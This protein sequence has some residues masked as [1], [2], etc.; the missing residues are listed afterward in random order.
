[1]K[2]HLYSFCSLTSL[3]VFIASCA[4]ADAQTNRTLSIYWNDVEGGGATLIVT[5]AGESILIDS[6]NPGARDPGRIYKT[7]SE[8][9]GLKK[10]DHYITTHFH[11]DHF[12][13][14]AELSKLIP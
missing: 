6:G 3:C 4:V 5:A 14:A 2:K 1:M 11:A 9:G 10:I 8:V 13:G 12:G 7:A